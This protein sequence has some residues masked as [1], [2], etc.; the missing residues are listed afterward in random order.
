MKEMVLI[1][2]KNQ[3]VRPFSPNHLMNDHGLQRQE[4]DLEA[5]HAA[6]NN[7]TDYD[8]Q[9]HAG[10]SFDD[11]GMENC[12]PI[13]HMDEL[14][15]D[16]GDNDYDDA[17]SCKT[18]GDDYD[19]VNVD[20][21]EDEQYD[22]KEGNYRYYDDAEYEAD[23]G[24]ERTVKDMLERY[25]DGS[26]DSTYKYLFFFLLLVLIVLFINYKK[27]NGKFN[28]KHVLIYFI[29]KKLKMITH[30]HFQYSMNK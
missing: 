29:D 9:L 8:N 17:A 22:V 23:P 15:G 24:Y 1:L 19:D 28:F 11:Q 4:R 6:V 16:L 30:C 10:D 5:N 26:D 27:N 13:E 3:R 20:S 25:E 21:L 2:L 12:A 14:G 18:C 7:P